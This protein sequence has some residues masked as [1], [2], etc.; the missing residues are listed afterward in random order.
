[1]FTVKFVSILGEP[2]Q[3]TVFARQQAS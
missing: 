1:L 2:V 3:V